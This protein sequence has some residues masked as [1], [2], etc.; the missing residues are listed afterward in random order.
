[1][2]YSHILFAAGDMCLGFGIAEVVIAVKSTD[3]R[4]KCGPGIWNSIVSASICNFVIVMLYVIRYR[5]ERKIRAGGWQPEQ[6]KK[7]ND[8]E[9]RAMTLS[10]SISLA[11]FIWQLNIMTHREC[12]ETFVNDYSSLMYMIY[13]EFIINRIVFG[14]IAVGLVATG[15]LWCTKYVIDCIDCLP[16]DFFRMRRVMRMAKKCSRQRL[17]A[18]ESLAAAIEAEAAYRVVKAVDDGF[19]PTAAGDT[20]HPDHDEA[21]I[22]YKNMREAKS[23]ASDAYNY[24]NTCACNLA[25][26]CNDHQFALATYVESDTYKREELYASVG[27]DIRIAIDTAAG[28]ACEAGEAS[29]VV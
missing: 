29:V 27:G 5:V 7:F 22:A 6:Y 1:M 16:F 25:V 17:R 23:I 13:I 21:V 11:M 26:M 14:L 10:V 4:D 12:V 8:T 3:S 2:K 19:D 20:N 28:E 9:T 15:L 18:E 24:A